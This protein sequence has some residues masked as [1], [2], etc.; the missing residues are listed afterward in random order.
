MAARAIKKQE[1]SGEMPWA[2]GSGSR[3]W[4]WRCWPCGRHG[5]RAAAVSVESPCTF[6]CPIAAGGGVDILA[7]TL[8]DVVSGNGVNRWWSKT[9]RAPAASSP[10][11][12]S[13]TSP[14]DG[15]TLIVVAS[16]HATNP[17]LYPKLPYDIF[18]DFT[19]ISLL[20]NVAEHPAGAR[21]FPR[22][23]R[24]RHDRAGPGQAGQ[25]VLRTCR[26]RHLDAS[27]RR[28]FEKPR[29]DRHHGDSL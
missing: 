27:C 7:R 10:R 26:Q 25:P 2:D 4:R 16:G 3:P 22:S 24:R 23:R 14:P 19:P 11:R 13:A 5:V 6:W 12:R 8:G 18:K 17:F 29:Q 9:G 15:Y 1:I 20:G 28:T 21:R